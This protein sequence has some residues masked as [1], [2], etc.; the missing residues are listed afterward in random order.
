MG[1]GCGIS[2]TNTD[3]NHPRAPKKHQKAN[4]RRGQPNS[5]AFRTGLSSARRTAGTLPSRKAMLKIA[6][7]AVNYTSPQ[8]EIEPNCAGLI[9]S[10]SGWL[11]QPKERMSI[12]TC[13]YIH[14]RHHPITHDSFL[15]LF[16]TPRFSLSLCLCLKQDVPAASPSRNTRLAACR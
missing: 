14:L 8:I 9:P 2:H 1:C 11:T 16:K 15:S 7:S 5:T 4:E 6:L 13:H 10:A 3:K 12:H